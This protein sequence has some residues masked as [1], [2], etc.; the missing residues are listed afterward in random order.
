MSPQELE[1]ETTG[2]FDVT[3]VEG[4]DETCRCG[5]VGSPRNLAYKVV[6][7]S[8]PKFL[9]RQG[10]VIDWQDIRAWFNTAYQDRAVFPSCEMIACEACEQVVK[11]L[12]GRA[13]KVEVTVGSGAVPAGMKAVWRR[14][15]EEI[16]R[17]AWTAPVECQYVN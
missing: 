9:D 12:D 5:P 11:M 17:E 15:M 13:T 2:R 6:I 4:A 8:A 16:D 3:V 7:T 1:L 14:S 10:F